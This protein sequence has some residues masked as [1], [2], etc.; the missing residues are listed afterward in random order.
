[1]H[2]RVPFLSMFASYEGGV[3]T[4][5]EYSNGVQ[6]PLTVDYWIRAA[7]LEQRRHGVADSARTQIDQRQQPKRTTTY[8]R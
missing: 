1:M 8:I 5:Q 4:Y 7:Q 2:L 3:D 6:H